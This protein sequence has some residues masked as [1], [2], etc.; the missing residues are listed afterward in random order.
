MTKVTR[1]RPR[2]F[3]FRIRPIRRSGGPPYWAS[4]RP[5]TKQLVK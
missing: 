5:F 4:L 2:T 1:R 3:D